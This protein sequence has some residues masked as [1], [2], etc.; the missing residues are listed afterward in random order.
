MSPCGKNAEHVCS[1]S[2]S[3]EGS[4]ALGV[5]GSHDPPAGCA[6]LPWDGRSQ[7]PREDGAW[8]AAA[9]GRA[10][11]SF[12]CCLP[13]RVHASACH[14][15]PGDRGA[16]RPAD[17]VPQGCRVPWQ[18]GM[19]WKV[20]GTPQ[21]CFHPRNSQKIFGQS[22]CQ[23]PG[24]LVTPIPREYRFQSRLQKNLSRL[25]TGKGNRPSLSVLY[26]DLTGGYKAITSVKKSATNKCK[27]SSRWAQDLYIW[28][29][30][31]SAANTLKNCGP[32]RGRQRTIRLESFH[33]NKI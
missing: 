19:Q 4:P 23:I 13:S 9:L 24:A 8:A 26:I 11:H 6:R 27:N 14:L 25:L 1:Q 22:K 16:R 12:A 29:H 32:G 20:P 2:L 7:G 3:D 5:P 10:V 21:A 15:F 17:L 30:L 18:R 31:C 33:L 28:P